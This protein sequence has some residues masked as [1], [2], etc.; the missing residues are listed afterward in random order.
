MIE[1]EQICYNRATK[2][3]VAIN[4]SVVQRNCHCKSRIEKIC[5]NRAI[6]DYWLST[7]LLICTETI[8]VN[9]YIT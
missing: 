2:H 3:L 8:I 5:Y 4:T 9:H 7:K 1:Q 6:E